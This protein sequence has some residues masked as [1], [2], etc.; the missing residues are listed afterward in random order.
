MAQRSDVTPPKQQALSVDGPDVLYSQPRSESDSPPVFPE[1]KPRHGVFSIKISGGEPDGGATHIETHPSYNLAWDA[2]QAAAEAKKEEL[3]EQAK[4]AGNPTP[5][6]M[7][8]TEALMSYYTVMVDG[9]FR[10]RYQVEPVK[11]DLEKIKEWKQ[12]SMLQIS[13]GPQQRKRQD[14]PAQANTSEAFMQGKRELGGSPSASLAGFST[15]APEDH[16]EPSKTHA[17]TVGSIISDEELIEIPPEPTN[18]DFE[19][20]T[21]ADDESLPV[22]DIDEVVSANDSLFNES[23]GA[24]ADTSAALPGMTSEPALTQ[25]LEPPTELTADTTT[26]L[27]ASD[28]A[29][30]AVDHDPASSQKAQSD[31]TDASNADLP[32]EAPIATKLQIEYGPAHFGLYLTLTHPPAPAATYRIQLNTSLD[33]AQSDMKLI[34][35]NE[36]AKARAQGVEDDMKLEMDVNKIDIVHKNGSRLSYEIAEGAFADGTFSGEMERSGRVVDGESY[37]RAEFEKATRESERVHR[38]VRPGWGLQMS[39][40]LT[41]CLERPCS[42]QWLWPKRERSLRPRRTRVKISTRIRPRWFRPTASKR[43]APRR[44]RPQ[45]SKMQCSPP[46]PTSPASA[47]RARSKHNPQMPQPKTPPPPKKLPPPRPLGSA[48]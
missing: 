5:N 31:V 39:L 44:A 12:Q 11:E 24:L 20:E 16:G 35:T 19:G 26:A 6:V 32:A 42:L 30:Q 47:S 3:E 43:P 46:S 38:C 22:Q 36:V 21:V 17:T 8:L 29:S 10:W 15:S 4:L 9:V 40:V 28:D 7:V 27:K 33:Q 14:T 23:A 1:P 25:H 34:V 45:K 2:A 13:S 41:S 48:R 18:S 37:T